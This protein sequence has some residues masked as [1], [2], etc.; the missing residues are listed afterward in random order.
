MAADNALKIPAPA[1]RDPKSFEVV[2]A[3]IAE[4]SLQVSL[5]T[6]VW[7]D[8]ADYGV[9]LFDVMQQIAIAYQEN[10]G[11]N[12]W[13]TMDKIKAGLEA[14]YAASLKKKSA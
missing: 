14:E 5:R 11:F 6:G 10:E 9:L 12:Q 2:R 1:M 13:E 7:D 3:W 4:S 8:P